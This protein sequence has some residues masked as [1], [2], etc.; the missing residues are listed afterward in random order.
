MSFVHDKT[1]IQVLVVGAGPVGLLAAL[2]LRQEGIDVR[3]VDQQPEHR[4]RTFPVVLHPRSLR[5]LSELGLSETLFWRGRRI[6]RLAIYTD[7]ERRAV[8]D[9]PGRG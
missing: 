6:T 1:R 7:Y 8:L 3:I 4:T 9:L 5:L 2:R